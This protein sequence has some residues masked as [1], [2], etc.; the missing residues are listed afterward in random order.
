MKRNNDL[1]SKG[2][3]PRRRGHPA[4]LTPLG[5]R[6]QQAMEAR[7]VSRDDLAA[8]FYRTPQAASNWLTGRC[9]L[10]IA[11]TEGLAKFLDVSP[12]WLAFGVGPSGLPDAV[13]VAEG[14]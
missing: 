4:R 12:S 11:H 8:A 14:A 7:G 1:R 9:H 3:T 6:L 10:T 5:S 13:L 2:K